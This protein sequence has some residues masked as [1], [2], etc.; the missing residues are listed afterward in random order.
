MR[1]FGGFGN[2]SKVRLERSTVPAHGAAYQR[3][4]WIHGLVNAS[5]M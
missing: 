4:F 3:R 2:L 5:R 1:C